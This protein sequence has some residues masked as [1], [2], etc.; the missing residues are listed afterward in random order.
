MTSFFSARKKKTKG[1]LLTLA[2]SFVN[3]KV[4]IGI[5]LYYFKLQT[6]YLNICLQSRIKWPIKNNSDIEEQSRFLR[7][8]VSQCCLGCGRIML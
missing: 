2:I 6:L 3:T 8:S 7:L 1:S 4:S 5:K